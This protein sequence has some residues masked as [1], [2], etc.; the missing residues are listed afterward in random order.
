M[1]VALHPDAFAKLRQYQANIARAN[2]V[3]SV[4]T[5]FSVQPVPHQ[6]MIQAYQKSAEF[7]GQINMLTVGDAHGQKLSL[8]ADRSV[9]ST[10]NTLINPRRPTPMGAIELIDEYLCTQTNYD[11]AYLWSLLNAWRH[12]PDFFNKLASMVVRQTALD[13][14]K[15]GWHG[16]FR[17]PTSD[18]T[19]YP[20][21][22]DVNIGWL[23]KIRQYAPERRLAD[24]SIG[25]G[26]DFKNID[27][28]IES[29]VEDLIGEQYRD[30]GLIAICGRGIVN[31]K[32]LPI[33]NQELA[34]TEQIAMRNI[35]GT[36]QLGTLPT[37]HVPYFPEKT[38]LITKPSNLSIY[39]QEG[40]LRR[41]LKD[42]PEWDRTSDFQS[43]NEAFVVED[44]EMVALLENVEYV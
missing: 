10:T 1:S 11:V 36:R 31:D 40:T 12:M 37:L 19:A 20:L 9:A 14:L 28:M 26:Q 38:I 3:D 25:G 42:E 29:A 13:K 6:K 18:K 27:A 21:L 24:I 30:A 17:S 16:E 8:N 2:Q 23:E 4:Q 34:P 5:T 39:I 33:M 41:Y 43:V 32:Y 35:Y 44:Y 7:L 15:I 22:N